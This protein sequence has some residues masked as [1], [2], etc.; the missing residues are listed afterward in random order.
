MKTAIALL[1]FCATM[2][3]GTIVVDAG[4]YGFC[5][6]D[7]GSPATE[8]C[9]GLGIGDTGNPIEFTALTNVYLQVTDAFLKGDQFD[10]WVN[11]ELLFTTSAVKTGDGSTWDPDTAFA[12]PTYSSGQVLLGPGAYEVNIF[13]AASPY[14]FGGAYVQVVT[15]R[16]PGPEVPEP[17][18]WALAAVGLGA[19][20]V[21]RRRAF[22]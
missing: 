21:F 6:L 16:I 5:F 19:V 18:T 10:V 7:A 2:S 1:V 13:A 8:G 17:S 22:R 9:Q 14:R 15:S 3:A 20:A 11:G 12:D 4:W